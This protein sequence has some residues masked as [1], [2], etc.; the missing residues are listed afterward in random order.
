[1][2][3]G[4]GRE[5]MA[6]ADF[7]KIAWFKP[8]DLPAGS[9]DKR[10]SAGVILSKVARTLVA[11]GVMG[12]LVEVD[13]ETGAVDVLRHWVVED[14]GTVIN[15]A[16]VD[17]QIMGGAAQGI[18]QVLGEDLRYDENGQL[19]SGTFMDYAVPRADIIPPMEIL[20]VTTPQAG[21]KL[22]QRASVKPEPLAARI[23]LECC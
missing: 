19:L 5:D 1:M 7:A 22:A 2:I 8:Y 18:G 15:R 21:T 4:A 17:G 10:P 11:N 13:P 3:R 20:H 14:C 9:T 6:L 12:C 23:S 16:L